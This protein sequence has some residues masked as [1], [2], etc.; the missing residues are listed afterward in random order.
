MFFFFFST[1]ES[2][3]IRIRYTLNHYGYFPATMYFE[4]LTGS[5]PFCIIREVEAVA[6]TPLADILGP[7]S[8]YKAVRVQAMNPPITVEVEGEPPER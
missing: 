5:T 4:F 6:K 8:P 2:C 3:E 1:G 7:I